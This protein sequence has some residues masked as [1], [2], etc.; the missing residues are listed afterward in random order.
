MI[1]IT[2]FGPGFGRARARPSHSLQV[3]QYDVSNSTF[4]EI[5]TRGRAHLVQPRTLGWPPLML[6][7]DPDSETETE[8]KP[9]DWIVKLP[10]REGGDRGILFVVVSDQQF[11]ENWTVEPD[12]K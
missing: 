9:G 4:V 1:H 10:V 3:M 7:A 2:G 8:L 11:R 5:F 6:R 12:D